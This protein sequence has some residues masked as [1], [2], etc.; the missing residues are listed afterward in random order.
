MI[1]FIAFAVQQNQ[2]GYLNGILDAECLVLYHLNY[3]YLHKSTN[4]VVSGVV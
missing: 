2:A 4:Y 1:S 3:I